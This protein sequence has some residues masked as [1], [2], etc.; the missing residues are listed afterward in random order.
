VR[1]LMGCSTRT[2]KCG[3]ANGTPASCT[4][5]A[6]HVSVQHE[7]SASNP[8]F[9]FLSTQ[10]VNRR[11]GDMF[12]FVWASYAGLR[13]L[14]WQVRGFRTQFPDLHVD[15]VSAKF[16]S[17]LP[18]PG[19]ID[20]DRICLRTE[21]PEHEQEFAK[22]ILFEACTLYENWAEKVCSEVFTP[23]AAAK[24]AKD[25]QFP[26]GVDNRGRPNGYTLAVAAANRSPS[27]LMRAEIYPKLKASNLNRWATVEEHLTAYRFFKECRNSIIHADGIVSQELIDVRS[28]LGAIQA[29]TASPFRHPFSLPPLSLGQP[30]R[31]HLKDCILF[32]TIVRLLVC[33]FDAAFAV[34]HSSE[35]LLESRVRSAKAAGRAFAMFPA[36]PTRYQRRV[37]RLL[38]AAKVPEPVNLANM[39]TWLQS[40]RLA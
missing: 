39:T 7:M 8:P 32:G 10:S 1:D 9:F 20:L 37:K 26:T 14:W 16:L 13:E 21:W 17:G 11:L 18:L 40:K 5:V 30:I 36:D 33:T 31:L 35:A 19:G 4:P 24:H 15:D 25:I 34:S 12:G 28:T 6:S 3:R 29:G 27:P 22:W 2:H 23:V 38:V